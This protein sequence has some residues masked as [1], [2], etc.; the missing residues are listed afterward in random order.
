[1]LAELGERLRAA[2]LERNL[3]QERLADEAGVGRVTVQRLEG[4]GSISLVSLIRILRALG[5]LDGLEGLL[6]APGPSPLEEAR[7]RGKRRQRARSTRKSP[8]QAQGRPWRW[9]DEEPGGGG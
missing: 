5:T 3:S 1:M 7:S 6:P 8:R 9:G 2:R 4:G